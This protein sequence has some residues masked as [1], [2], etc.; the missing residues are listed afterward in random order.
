MSL[1]MKKT[2]N[3]WLTWIE[4]DEKAYAHNLA[5]FRQKIK[6]G[7]ELSVVVKANAYG[8]GLRPIVTLAQ[9]YGVDSYCVKNTGSIPIV[10]IPWM[11]PWRCELGESK[12]I[13]SS[14]DLSPPLD[15]I[16]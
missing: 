8:H 1:E 7:V 4:L 11:R 5:F 10:S 3:D 2:T 16:R 13:F 6:P 12:K 15:S 14:W 9:K